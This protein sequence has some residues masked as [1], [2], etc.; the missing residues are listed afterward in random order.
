MSR[1]IIISEE[2]GVRLF[3]AAGFEVKLNN[4][5]FA[6]FKD[7]NKK[8]YV[9]NR[10]MLQD[11]NQVVKFIKDD[12]RNIGIQLGVVKTQN[13]IKNLLGLD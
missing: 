13:Q 7:G 2:L 4:L 8:Y 12:S 10:G 6:L 3:E 5:G 1:L 11:I 9:S